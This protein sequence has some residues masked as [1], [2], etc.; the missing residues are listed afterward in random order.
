MLAR[1]LDRIEDKQCASLNLT[2]AGQAMHLN[3]PRQLQCGAVRLP[4]HAL[5]DDQWGD[6][7]VFILAVEDARKQLQLNRGILDT[8]YQL[9]S[10][11]ISVCECVLTGL[12]PTQIAQ[13]QSR[14]INTIKSQLR[15]VY[16]KTGVS[17]TAQLAR[18]L[19]FNPAY[20]VGRHAE[21][22]I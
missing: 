13:L 12:E 10:A 11:E 22:I 7:Q 2:V 4:V 20:W 21:S 1:K 14:S 16:R 3:S 6:Q 18:R 19:F 8:I 17:N 9:S 5:F 15:S